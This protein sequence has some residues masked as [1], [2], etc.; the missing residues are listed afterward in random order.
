[1]K[2]IGII[3]SG[4]MGANTAFFVAEKAVGNVILFD[5]KDG[6]SQGK[7]LDMMEVA[8]IRSYRASVAG[9]DSIERIAEADI[10]IITAG[11]VRQ[12]GMKREE[13]YE[14]NAPVVT[15]I[16]REL[17]KTKAVAVVVSEPVDYL[18]TLFV[19][20]SGL[21]SERVLGVGGC[22][23]SVR[24]Q[25]LLAKR[26]GVAAGNVTAMVVGPHSD[27]MIPLKDYCRISGIPVDM[28]LEEKEIQEAFE[29]TRNA[30]DLILELAARTS[31][32]YGPSA[33]AAEIAETI[34][35]D[36]GRVLSVSTLLTGQYGISG[37]A[38]SLPCIVGENGIRKILEPELDRDQEKSLVDSGETISQ[39]VRA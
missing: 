39:T 20:V 1:M 38:L 3:G 26:A 19:K 31:A 37:V 2:T 9:V 32:Y 36:N 12:P 21:P 27:R 35:K 30:G 17:E 8:P 28:I 5:V 7:A 13:L 23:D 15:E 34:A 14:V 24:L 22:L 18:T 16:A 29:E 10:I 33:V 4:N 25:F 6:L 11:T